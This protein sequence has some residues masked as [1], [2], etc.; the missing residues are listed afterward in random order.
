MNVWGLIFYKLLG[1]KSIVDRPRPN[2]C[3]ICIAPHTSNW[4]FIF[5]MLYEKATGGKAHFL[6]KSEW[7]VGPLKK[8]LKSLGGIPVERIKVHSRK[9]NEA[10]SSMP[11]TPFSGLTAILSQRMNEA[12][13]FQIAITPE[14]TRS[15]NS[16]WHTGFY[17]IARAANVP[18][19]LFVIDYKN[20][21]IHCQKELMPSADK[22]ADIVII[23]NYYCH[24]AYAAKYP[25][26]F[27]V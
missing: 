9:D 17:H 8:I 2:K 25:K 14:G 26:K 4:D 3:V 13:D 18:I 19:L 12:S 22:Q 23:K 15:L 24:Y 1:W 10:P 5:A 20:K 27:G 16:E 11:D 7:F 6:M 21:C